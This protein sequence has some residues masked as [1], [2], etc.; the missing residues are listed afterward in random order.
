MR[1]TKKVSYKLAKPLTTLALVAA[2]FGCNKENDDPIVP[3]RDTAVYT[4][5]D[6]LFGKPE[7]IEQIGRSADSANIRRVILE[8]D[9]LGWG[10]GINT[11]ELRTLGVERLINTAKEENRYK[12]SGRNTLFGVAMDDTNP[13]IYKQHQIDSAWLA[14]FGFDFKLGVFYESQ[15]NKQR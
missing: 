3:E 2:S 11:T 14:D 8:S 1:F 5:N 9:D 15:R 10:A 13:E 12:F 6:F 7:V 4:F